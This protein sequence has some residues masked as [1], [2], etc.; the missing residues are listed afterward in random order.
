MIRDILDRLRCDPSTL[1][2]ATLIEEREAAAAEIEQLRRRLEQL[3]DDSRVTRAPAP[4]ERLAPD[5]ASA[6]HLPAL[7]AMMDFD[8]VCSLLRVSRSTLSAWISDETFPSPLRIDDDIRWRVEDV[9][10]WR[11]KHDGEASFNW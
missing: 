10:A 4:R 9:E 11:D 1:T 8:D 2:T 5:A 3:G 6:E 7:G